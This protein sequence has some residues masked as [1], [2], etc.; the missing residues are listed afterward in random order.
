[1][2]QSLLIKNIFS[3][4]PVKLTNNSVEDVKTN[5]KQI[6]YLSNINGAEIM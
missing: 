2:K 3:T 5:M 4:M 1:M 6:L